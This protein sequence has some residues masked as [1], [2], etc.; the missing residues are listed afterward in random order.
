MRSSNDFWRGFSAGLA[1]GALS[2]AGTMLAWR[3]FS[4]AHDRRILRIESSLQ[5]GRPVH[6]VFEQ[7]CNLENL[8][9]FSSLIESIRV[10]GPRSHW[11]VWADGKIAEWDAELIQKIPNEALGWKSVRGPKHT[12]RISFSPLQ[13][14]TLVHLTMNYA[15]PLG[16]FSRSIPP[17]A[18]R[19]QRAIEQVMRDFKLAMEQGHTVEA[20][21]PTG[22]FAAEPLREGH[23][24][25][26][27]F[28]G[29]TG[30]VEIVRPP[31]VTAIPQAED[32]E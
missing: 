5:I 24:Q 21:R 17:F 26:S 28:G 1:A 2:G 12:G 29:A 30:P 31:A 18:P 3:E 10:R 9:R 32:K 27:R 7:W 19:I 13:Q 23:M 22:T 8:P 14:D 25:H 6:E 4:S 16:M 20:A 11:R 15:P